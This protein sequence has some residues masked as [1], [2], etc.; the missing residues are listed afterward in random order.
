MPCLNIGSSTCERPSRSA[1]ATRG[2]API[3]TD[4]SAPPNEILFVQGLPGACYLPA[5]YLPHPATQPSHTNP[6]SRAPAAP[7]APC[8]ELVEIVL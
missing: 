4:P 5:T 8:L 7:L 1:P 3:R 6:T 2:T